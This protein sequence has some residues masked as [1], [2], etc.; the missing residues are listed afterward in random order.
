MSDL[1]QSGDAWVVA[2]DGGR[3]WGKFGAAGLL[4]HDPARGIL[5]QHRVSW[6]DHGGTWGIPGG[7]RHENE[8]AVHGAVRESHEEAGVPHDAVQPRYAYVIDRG[9]WTYTTIIAQVVTPF[10]P[11]ITDPESH[12]LAWVPLDEVDSYELHPG[13][14][15]SWPVLRP[16]LYEDP[17]AVDRLI[18][19]G[20]LTPLPR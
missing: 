9:G 4:A 7:A 14:A 20:L 10:E 1:R 12:A 8:S 3:Y 5:L 13:F 16:A 6:S 2:A 17:E 19:E 18:A 15:A 11:E